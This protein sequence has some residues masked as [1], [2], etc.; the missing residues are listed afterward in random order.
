MKATT[1]FQILLPPSLKPKGTVL[2]PTYDPTNS[3]DVLKFPD[4]QEHKVD[5]F[6]SRLQKNSQELIKEIFSQDPDLSNT[7]WSFLTVANT[8]PIIL[9]KNPED[10]IDREAITMCKQLL[11][12]LS[13]VTDYTQGYVTRKSLRKHAEEL[14][15]ML[16]LRGAAGV[17]AVYNEA[18][19]LSEIRN[20]DMYTVRWYEKSPGQ[21]KPQQEVGEKKIKLDIPTFFC[22]DLYKDPTSAY[23]KSPFTAAINTIAATQQVI[24]DLYRIMQITGYPR[25]DV[26]I[27]EEVLLKNAPVELKNDPNLRQTYI[28]SALSQITSQFYNLRPDLPAVH[29]DSVSIKMV[30]D[31]KPGMSVDISHVI[32]VL[33][34]QKQSGLHTLST[35]LGRGESGVNTATV[36][37]RLFTMSAAAVNDPVADLLS[38]ILTQAI[39]IMGSPSRVIVKFP[40]PELRSDEELEAQRVLK[41][42]RLRSDLS[43]GLISDD[44]YALEMYG[45]L[46]LDGSTPLSG[47]LFESGGLQVDASK[48]SP[49]SDPIGRSVSQ[50]SD[51]QAKSNAVASSKK[52]RT[53]A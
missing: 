15:H 10:Q 52:S 20:V 46:P 51:K 13:T 26:S 43:Y 25:M 5:L 12:N 47:T 35:I 48:V 7:V 34:A 29:L 17:E 27:L 44:E 37:A 9:A 28:N 42:Q 22:E 38:A 14:R 16:L 8:T 49:N 33:D 18:Y 32:K 19:V 11:A 41:Q 40:E 6:D 39:R 2:T 24:N 3:K 31:S 30:N 21:M 45:R 36:E 50:A 4:F 1:P 23:A 53:K